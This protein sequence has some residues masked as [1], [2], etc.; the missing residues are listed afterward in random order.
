MKC[1]IMQPH[2]LPWPGYFNLMSQVD[3]FIFLDDAQ[4]SKNSWHNRNIII[5]NTKKIWLT[6]PLKKSSINT[7]IKDK[8]IDD[9]KKW[10]KKHIKT[11]FQ[12]YSKHSHATDLEEFISFLQD[13]RYENLSDCNIKIIIFIA[14]KLNINTEFL[15]TS[16]F[17][18]NEKRTQKLIKIL[19]KVGAK[20]YISPLGGKEYLI[21]DSFQK[22]SSVKLTI[23]NYKNKKYNQKNS[24]EFISNLSIV[25]AIAN[26]G[27]IGAAKYVMK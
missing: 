21:E 6:I 11:L 3:K 25:D 12:C 5:N 19:E 18:I 22:Y 8:L 26:S 24:K 4:Y 10:R 20:E 13:L 16:D 9:E 2:Y 14:K 15:N 1:A 7:S 17:S 27:W 23:N